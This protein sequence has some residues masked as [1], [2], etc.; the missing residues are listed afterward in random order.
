RAYG[1]A[2]LLPLLRIAHGNEMAEVSR[3]EAWREWEDSIL[4]RLVVLNSR[5]AKEEANGVINW[6]RPEYQNP[7]ARTIQS[8]ARV[9]I[10]AGTTEEIDD[11]VAG[12][13]VSSSKARPWP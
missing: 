11:A 8:Q 12:P 6:L 10:G 9:T 4:E 13:A 3:E 5:R 1:W 2:D 7:D